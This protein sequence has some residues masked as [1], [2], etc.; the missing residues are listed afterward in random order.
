MLRSVLLE[1]LQIGSSPFAQREGGRRKKN[2]N[3]TG[4]EAQ[5][6]TSLYK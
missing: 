5:D 4:L 3:Q 2:T 6:T 1:E